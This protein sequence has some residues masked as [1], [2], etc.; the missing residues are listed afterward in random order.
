MFFFFFSSRRRHT[1]L[2]GDWS[3]DVCS[4]D[5][6]DAQVATLSQKYDAAAAAHGGGTGQ[7]EWPEPACYFG[8]ISQPFGCVTLWLEM[9]APSCPYPHRK[10]TG[11]DIAGPYRTPIV[12]ADTG[13]IYP[14]PGS[15]GY[16]NMI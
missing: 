11:L 10:H 13:I 7:F 16:G 1:R 4:S 14:Y 15:I 9:Y 12:A 3:S 2:Q 8:C 6:I 5:L